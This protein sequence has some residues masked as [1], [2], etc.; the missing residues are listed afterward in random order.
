MKTLK[1]YLEETIRRYGATGSNSGMGYTLEDAAV[2][3]GVYSTGGSIGSQKFKDEPV[4]TFDTKEEAIAD[5]RRRR[6]GLSQGERGYYRM[7]Y[8]VRPIKDVAEAAPGDPE[9][10]AANN[11]PLL[12]KAVDLAPVKALEESAELKLILQRAKLVE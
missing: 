2:K 7:S 11:D 4:K 1:D 8:V 5:A 9:T 12:A 10:D 6:S 3:Y